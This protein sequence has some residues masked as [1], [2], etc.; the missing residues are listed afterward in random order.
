MNDFMILLWLANLT[1]SQDIY[2]TLSY[3]R[4][5]SRSCVQSST[6]LSLS[7]SQPMS[8]V[9]H[10]PF[11]FSFSLVSGHPLRRRTKI[12]LD[13]YLHQYQGRMGNEKVCVSHNSMLISL[14]IFFGGHSIASC[15]L[16]ISIFFLSWTY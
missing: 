3:S 11:S 14:Y 4:A 8:L 13:Q 10:H 2:S 16:S 5:A 15:L 9:S 12:R 7:P 1:A 6:S